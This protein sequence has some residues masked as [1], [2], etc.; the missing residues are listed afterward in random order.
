MTAMSLSI[1]V[2]VDERAPGLPSHTR[3]SDSRGFRDVAKGAVPFIAIE[4][5]PAVM[6]NEQVAM[7]IVVVVADADALGPAAAIESRLAGDVCE[8][9]LAQVAIEAARGTRVASRRIQSRRAGDEHVLQTVVIEIEDG[10]AGAGGFED[11]LLR[12]SRPD[13]T[14]RS[15]RP[16]Q[17]S[18]K[19]TAMG[20]RS[21]STTVA[22]R[23][24]RCCAPFPGN[25][26]RRP[27]PA[28]RPA[29]PR[30]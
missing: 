23:G 8:P 28:P 21:V 10:D 16:A 14:A 12:S 4:H 27:I 11:V 2:V 24:T 19:S 3:Q 25:L 13:T 26:R 22:G 1:E 29:P 20:G 15:S 9:K 6:R 17:P 18:R 30:R 7:G 5:A